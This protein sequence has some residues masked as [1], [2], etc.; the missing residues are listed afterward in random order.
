M[1]EELGLRELLIAVIGE[2][3]ELCTAIQQNSKAITAA[4]G[5]KQ[6]QPTIVSFDDQTKRD[7][8]TENDRLYRV[9]NSLR[10]AIWL[11]FLAAVIYAGV[12]AFTYSQIVKQYFLLKQSADAAKTSAEAA[13]GAATTTASN[14]ETQ[15]K[16]SRTDQ[17][18]YLIADTPQFVGIPTA[19]KKIQ[20]NITLRNVGKTPAMKIWWSVHLTPYRFTDNRRQSETFLV[21][22][23]ADL[24][25]R[26]DNARKDVR[27]FPL[28]VDLAPNAT[29]W[30]T[31]QDNV[32]L[33][34]GLFT[35]LR[36]DAI[37]LFC[38]GL[39]GYTDSY[40]GNYETD[41]CYSYSGDEPTSWR[42]CDMFNAIQ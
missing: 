4:Q 23:F 5:S 3:E 10:W 40:G 18:P 11:A 37:G 39:I 38:S 13:K 25:S 6:P 2:I 19:N 29:L 35:D 12:A 33:N 42:V 30:E 16:W 20:A 17:R 7:L 41:F 27:S 34:S 24:Q 8:R 36:T 1:A 32:V 28:E 31:S 9:Q 15:T 22:V 26:R 14:L 21:S